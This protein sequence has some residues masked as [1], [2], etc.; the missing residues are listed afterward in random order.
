MISEFVVKLRE[1][2]CLVLKKDKNKRT[3]NY[4]TYDVFFK[5]A[6]VGGR[7]KESHLLYFSFVN[8][9]VFTTFKEH[10]TVVVYP[11]IRVV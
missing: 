10:I 11:L 8:T 9:N 4:V 3:C 2:F 5:L 1:L 6:K 7:L